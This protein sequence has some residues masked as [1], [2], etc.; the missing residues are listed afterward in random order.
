M[1]DVVKSGTPSPCS[2]LWPANAQIPG[3]LSGEA[4]AAGDAC[5][6]KAA[7]GK[8]WKSIGTAIN[9]AA[10]VDGFAAEAASVGEAVSL[11]FDMNFHYGAALT[12]GARL[13]V[14]ATAPGGLLGDAAT[15]GGTGQVGVVVDATRIH[16]WQS[17][18]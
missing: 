18:Y 9:A 2:R 4:L 3:L 12:P 1:A 16:V 14:S 10:K 5:Y 8:V 7:D 17:R 13:Y 11:L 6:I 15:T